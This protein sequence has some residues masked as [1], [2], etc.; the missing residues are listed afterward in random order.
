VKKH[1][2]LIASAALGLGSVL[3]VL[4]R[5]GYPHHGWIGL[6]SY[7]VSVALL[8]VALRGY[9]RAR[10]AAGLLRRHGAIVGA[11]AAVLLVGYVLWVLFPVREQ[12]FQDLDAAALDRVLSDD[13]A[14]V[15]RLVAAHDRAL[16]PGGDGDVLDRRPFTDLDEAGRQRVIGAWAA[17][18]DRSV[19]LE[20]LALRHRHFYQIDFW[21]HPGQNLRSFLIG[22]AA[23]L[24]NVK[25]GV[26]WRRRVQGNPTLATALDDP[27]PELGIPARA[28]AHVERGLAHPETAILLNAGRLHLSYARRSGELGAPPEM[29]LLA[30][31]DG[32]YTEIAK[33]LGKQPDLALDSALR[34]Y[35]D[36][37]LEVWFPLQ[38]EVSEAM[39][40]IRTTGRASLITVEQAHAARAKLQ[41]G[42]IILERR[43]WYLSNVGLPGFWPHAALYVGDLTELDRAFAGAPALGGTSVSTLLAERFPAV[44]QRY[45]A[46]DA[47]GNA[48]SVLEAVSEGVVLHPFESSAAA[49]YVA[50]IRPRLDRDDRL[51]A[52]L[53]AFGYLGRPYDFDFDF[54]TDAAVVCSELVYKAYRPAAG[55]K[56]LHF[57]LALTAGRWVVSP[58]D[59]ANQFDREYGT[60][61]QQLDFV[62]F[63]DG[64]EA[65][66]RAAERDVLTFRQSA[67]RP[68]WD[69]LQQ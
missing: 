68:K 63:L 27:R 51:A 19:A 60:P 62:L 1:L 56:G 11:A 49:D 58:T 48:P 43:N 39:G 69:F 26:V 57:V 54:V 28:F 9:R 42:D 18:V 53:E 20:T 47:D 37:T 33:T 15:V 13:L 40:D 4:L 45:A 14:S 12:P 22:Y 65:Q 50:V 24:A 8:V 7:L 6:G 32:A 64:N 16:A 35:Q 21:R 55:R 5:V 67:R 17:F 41:S 25:A 59:I 36:T 31:C 30:F 10:L 23:L 2:P 3:V 61:N 66:H 29:R 52:L 34:V 38:K 44:S 46:R